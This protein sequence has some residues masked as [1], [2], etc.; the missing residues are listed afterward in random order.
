V[1]KKNAWELAESSFR[2]TFVLVSLKLKSNLIEAQ[3]AIF[4][5]SL[6][7]NRDL[8]K[9]ETFAIFYPVNL[10]KYSNEPLA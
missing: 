4:Y 1:S 5:L 9:L 10:L 7:E 8:L 2:V 6:F 3:E